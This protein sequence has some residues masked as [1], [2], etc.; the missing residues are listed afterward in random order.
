MN[1]RFGM[2]LPGAALLAM[3]LVGALIFP[4]QITNAGRFISHAN[5]LTDYFMGVSWAVAIGLAL[6]IA[7]LSNED[8]T[9]LIYGWV[10]K[11]FVTLIVMLP[12]EFYYDTDAYSYFYGSLP[13]YFPWEM[14][15]LGQG[16]NNILALAWVHGRFL[17]NSYHAMKVSFSLIGLFALFL[18]YKAAV[19]FIGG[20]NP[21]L[22][23]VSALFPSNLFW[24]SI[25]GKDPIILLGIAVYVYG[26]ASWHRSGGFRKIGLILVGVT[27]AMFIRIWMGPILLAPF[28]IMLL[29]R[30]RNLLA[31]VAISIVILVS[32]SFSIN[33]T[34]ERF[35]IDT[36]QDVLASADALAHGEGWA[37][38]SGQ[39]MEGSILNLGEMLAF[40]PIGIVTALFRPFPGEIM[41]AFGFMAGMENLF[42]L[43]LLVLAIRRTRLLELLDPPVLWALSLLI[44]WS[45][46]YGVV[47]YRNLGAA[48]RFRLQVLPILLYLLLYLGRPRQRPYPKRNANDAVA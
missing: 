40:L 21:R 30:F 33:Q 4:D 9:L 44:L 26:V 36:R 34:R 24:S 23:L 37:G 38:G 18:L 16:T 43:A 28:G 20:R 27:T 3:V 19:A 15:R 6:F 29:F 45:S 22:F 12:Y 39:E 13:S 31:K 8:R 41:N 1:A 5:I 17:P 2:V 11:C 46:I 14:P 32:L 42:L 25:I 10:A 35:N 47:S 7:P 48:V